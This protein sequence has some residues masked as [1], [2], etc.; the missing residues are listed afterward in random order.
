MPPDWNGPIGKFEDEP[1]SRGT[2]AIA[3]ALA[4]CSGTTIV[5]STTVDQISS[6]PEFVSVRARGKVRKDTIPRKYL[7]CR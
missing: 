6:R 2:K 7:V 4:E 5:G 1:Y 3:E